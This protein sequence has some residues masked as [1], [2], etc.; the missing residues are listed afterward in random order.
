[1]INDERFTRPLYSV[2]G[3]ARLVGMHPSTLRSWSQAPGDSNGNGDGRR[4][5]I[6][7]L[8]R[9]PRDK[10]VIPFVGL[11]EAAV[12]QVFRSSG[13]SLQRIRKALEVLSSQGEL[14]HALASRHMYTDGANVLYQYADQSND[15]K[16]RSLTVVF[17]GQRVFR[18]AIDRYL[19]RIT[20][21]D[22]W[23]TELILPVTERPLLRVLPNV[24]LGDALFMNGGA[25]L[26]AVRS[27][28][29]AG[30]PL[31]SISADFD[32]PVDDLSEGLT[33]IWPEMSYAS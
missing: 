33:A 16:L 2:A 14:E 28:A 32:T 26:S 19:K 21:G 29:Y 5:I 4:A 24:A 6:T 18:D 10:R 22:A 3:A 25:P 17:S 27:R 30:E 11:T 15:K 23:A 8:N 9:K 20:F 7:T 31:A 1:M 13:L 12:V